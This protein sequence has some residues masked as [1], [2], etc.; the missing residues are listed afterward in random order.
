L[1]HN[2]H[3][4]IILIKM[5]LNVSAEYD[6]KKIR[7]KKLEPFIVTLWTILE[8]GSSYPPT[9]FAVIRIYVK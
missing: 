5:L 2:L 7:K 1:P 8:N 6:I 9:I 4:Q 3:V